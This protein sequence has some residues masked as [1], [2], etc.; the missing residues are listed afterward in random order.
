MT[1]YDLEVYLFQVFQQ[2]YSEDFAQDGGQHDH[3]VVS[4]HELC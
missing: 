2:S 3:H 1:A 4:N